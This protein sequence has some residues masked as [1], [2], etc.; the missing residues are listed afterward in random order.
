[1][2]VILVMIMLGFDN[3]RLYL[4]LCCIVHPMMMISQLEQTAF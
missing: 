4:L 1:M 2:A 3:V